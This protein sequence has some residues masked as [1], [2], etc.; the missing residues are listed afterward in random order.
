MAT[1]EGQVALVTGGGS[2]IGAAI[3][4]ALAAARAR[5]FLVGRTRQTLQDIAEQARHLGGHAR[6]FLADLGDDAE[7]RALIGRLGHDLPRL[8]I[9]VQNAGM[10]LS[11][12]VARAPLANLDQQFRVNL[13]APYALVQALLPLLEASQGQ[14]VFVNSSSGLGAKPGTGQYAST[15]HALKALA[16]SLRAEVNSAGI[17]VLSV[18]LGRTASA[19]QKKIHIEENKSYCPERLLQP[20][21]VASV[22]LNALCLPRTAEVTDVHIRPM[23]GPV[24]TDP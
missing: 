17:R 12:T 8:D 22:V 4:L 18:Y 11:G 1:L 13:R 15:K 10:H 19:L 2:G 14:V 3:A 9:L 5:V 7:L 23:I 6:Y 24:Q 20:Q 16:D 21:D